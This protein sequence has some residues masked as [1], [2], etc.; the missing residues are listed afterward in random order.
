MR[1][2]FHEPVSNKT[3]YH[4]SMRFDTL[5]SE[6]LDYLLKGMETALDLVCG[7]LRSRKY[8]IVQYEIL[9]YRGELRKK[10]HMRD[11]GE[12]DFIGRDFMSGGFNLGIKEGREFSLPKFQ[13]RYKELFVNVRNDFSSR[14]SSL[15]LDALIIG[16][17]DSVPVEIEAQDPYE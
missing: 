6:D 9:F 5:D 14:P 4:R 13:R 10:V 12:I 2:I 16:S 8:L 3:L 1:A 15:N 7:R 17:R 11:L